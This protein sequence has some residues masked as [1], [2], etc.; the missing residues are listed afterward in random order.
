MIRYILGAASSGKSLEIHQ[1]IG[2]RLGKVKQLL[3]VPE[4]YTLQAEIDLIRDLNVEGIIDVEVMS[5]NRFCTRVLSE[6]GGIEA[7]EINH[8]GKAMVLRSLLDQHAEELLVFSDICKKTGFIDKLSTLISEMKR[9]GITSEQLTLS[10][11]SESR[12]L[13]R[14]ISDIT[15]ILGLYEGFMSKG[16]YDEEDRLLTVIDRISKSEV[17]NDTI[18]YYDGFDSFSEQ[19]YQMMK[20]MFEASKASVIA[21]SIQLDQ[22]QVVQD[23]V[24]KTLKKIRAISESLSLQEYKKQVNQKNKYEDLEHLKQHF[25]EFPLVC[26]ENDVTHIA[27]HMHNNLYDEIESVAKDIQN[28]IRAGHRYKDFMVVTGQIES[29]GSIV[30]RVFNEYDI[31]YFID[32]KV[33]IMKHPI[34]KYI[35]SSLACINSGFKRQDVIDVMKTGLTD[36][37]EALMPDFEN[38]IIKVGLRGQKWLEPFED[39]ALDEQRKLLIE[40]LFALK[41]NLPSKA[42]ISEMTKGLF[43]YLLNNQ[44]P[45]KIELWIKYLESKQALDKVQESTQIWNVIIEIF[46]QLIELEGDDIKTVKEFLRILEA[47]FNE[48]TLGLIPPSVDQVVIGSIERSKTKGME[49]LYI[50]G[51]N[52]GV[53]PKKYGDEGLILDDE[54]RELKARGIDLETDASSIMARDYFS[55]YAALSKAKSFIRFSFP[56][57]DVEGKALRPSIYVDRLERLFKDLKVNSHL[58]D[59]TDPL[60]AYNPESHYKDLTDAFRTLADGYAIDE[61]WYGVLSWY[62][63]HE[64]WQH[65][66]ESLE[67]ALFYDNQLEHIDHAKRLYNLPLISSISRLERF[68]RCP[69]SHFIHYGL[70]PKKRETYELELPDIGMLFHK[71]LE[72]FDKKMKTEKEDWHH[73]TQE[74]TFG[75]IEEIV[76][77]LVEKYKYS[78]FLS[79][80]R[81]MYHIKKLKRIGKRAAWTLVYQV[82]QGLFMPHAHEVKFDRNGPVMPIVIELSN[83]DRM[84]LEGQIDRIDTFTTDLG[85]GYIKIIDYKSGSK[86]FSLSEVYQGLQLQLMVYLDAILENH[87][88]FRKEA[89]YPAGVF[90]FKIDDPM[91]ES[92][93]L[94]GEMTAE[95][96]IKQLKMDGLMVDNMQIAKAMDQE[97]VEVRKSSVIPFELKKD[98]SVSSRSKVAKEEAFYGLIDHV[99]ET[100]KTIGDGI[101]DG[102][103]RIEPFKLGT[104]TGCQSCDYQ[105]ICQF[106]AAFG[107]RYKSMK[108]YKDDEVLEFIEKGESHAEVDE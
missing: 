107:N 84:M 1:M 15:K 30:K 42:K 69:F 94:K 79:S 58:M 82:Q 100:V 8:L 16:Y 17:L 93:V 29:Y 87:D 98:D 89:L 31:P 68:S 36:M 102:V 35:L 5:F 40:P 24:V 33:S 75:Y 88:Y 77:H 21:L 26:Y 48:V 71:T 34:V 46:D 41:D 9:V 13:D 10:H 20:A 99:K 85:K 83:G 59:T 6:T 92:E 37:N 22:K 53:M 96:I 45:E 50:V 54:K 104:A 101:T 43:E 103:T 3:I 38:L 14:K 25:F 52:D 28:K 2:E 81:F 76:D 78:I 19:E 108:N 95:E 55:T 39:E 91:I 56:L 32:D 18:V 80:H 44:V 65:R 61:N 51:L 97:I 7:T 11:S 67:D 12:M 70:K 73:I 4:Q 74:K 57:S 64:N 105:S 90:Y 49:G 23:P 62:H 106:D 72:E 47:G 66:I 63:N 86:K 27:L 60:D